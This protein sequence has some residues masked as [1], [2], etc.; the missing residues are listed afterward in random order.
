MADLA[1]DVK[2]RR[3]NR[4]GRSDRRGL[5][6]LLL[7]VA[8]AGLWVGLL[9]RLHRRR[10]DDGPRWYLLVYRIIYRL[11]FIVWKRANPPAEL[12][13]LV[14]GPS[15]LPAGRALDLGCGTGTDTIYLATH[16]WDVTGVDMTPRALAIAQRNA[17]AAGV[18]PRLIHGDVT[19]LHDLGVGD[20]YTLVLDFGCFHTLPG[21]RRP[22]YVTNVSHAAAPGATL[23]MLGFCRRGIAPMQAGMTVDEVRQL[24]TAA[25]WE[26]I[27]AKRASADNM[28][29]RGV[30]RA[31][32]RFEP[33]RYQLR[34]TAT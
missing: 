21:D 9:G 14:E 30:G 23:L 4:D 15:A 8:V 25:G 16:G 10:N 5:T 7:M 11:G 20:G 18:T 17:T 26:L 1:H 32:G 6:L 27:T 19:R 34:R 28:V 29:Q 3:R 12:V 22:P 2:I 33:W 24:F 13:A 31:V